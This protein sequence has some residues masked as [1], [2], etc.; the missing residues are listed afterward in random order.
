M[1]VAAAWAAGL[2]LA[3]LLRR[4]GRAFPIPPGWV[5]RLLTATGLLLVVTWLVR[6]FTGTLPPV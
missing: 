1:F 3:G 6:L 2:W 5:S 4:Q